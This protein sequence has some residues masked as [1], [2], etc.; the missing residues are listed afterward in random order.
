MRAVLQRVKNAKVRVKEE[1][2]GEINSGILV[3]L[4]I[5]K[6]D[7]EK[8]IENLASKIV[9][10]RIF[11]DENGKMNFSALSLKKEIMIVSQFTLYAD[12][13]KG[14]RP[15]FTDALEPS[16]AEEFYKKFVE[17]VKQYN[18]KV[19]TGKFGEIMEIET[20]QDGPVTIIL[21]VEKNGN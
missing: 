18:L 14:N 1:I 11:P 20:T 9:N 10:L 15:S 13:K 21:E 16:L 19:A 2:V 3:F 4:G 17:K 7:T 12:C 8:E 6:N 5:G